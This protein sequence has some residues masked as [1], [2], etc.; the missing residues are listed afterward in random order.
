MCVSEYRAGAGG[1]EPP[2]FIA[3]HH[4]QRPDAEGNV[5][6]SA[7]VSSNFVHTASSRPLARGH[8]FVVHFDPLA[9]GPWGEGE[10]AIEFGVRHD[11]GSQVFQGLEILAERRV[12]SREA[13]DETLMAA[14]LIRSEIGGF[15]TASV[16]P[17]RP[18]RR[19]RA[20]GFRPIRPGIS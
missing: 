5:C 10:I 6:F 16:S 14:E 8:A 20:A 15:P 11:Q 4:G 19:F 3:S 18:Q 12:E 13:I 7:K 1:W 9:T 2:R 17:F